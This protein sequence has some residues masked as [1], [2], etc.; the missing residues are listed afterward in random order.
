MKN[1]IQKIFKMVRLLVSYL[2]HQS[3]DR[4]SF[5]FKIYKCVILNGNR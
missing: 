3:Y 1:S 2:G 4:V 5:T